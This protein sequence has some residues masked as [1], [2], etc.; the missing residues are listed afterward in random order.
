MANWVG[1]DGKK[2]QD[3]DPKGPNYVAAGWSA[4]TGG[5]KV[6]SAPG[7]LNPGDP[8]QNQT[9]EA[10]QVIADR[11]AYDDAAY[12][13][14]QIN[15][16]YNYGG[17]EGGANEA[18]NYYQGAAAG[19]QYRKGAQIDTSETGA[20]RAR[21]LEIAQLMDDRAHG[22]TPSIAEMEAAKQSQILT[23]QQSSAAAS[24]RGPA[25]LA[26]AQ[27]GAAAN[28]AA[29]ESSIARDTQINAAHERERAEAAALSGYSGIRGADAQHAAAQAA[30]D[31][32]KQRQNDAF[33]NANSDRAVGINT[34]QLGAQMHQVDTS[35]G[36]NTA[37]TVAQGN[38]DSAS[39]TADANRNQAYVLPVIGGVATGIGA[40]VTSYVTG[41]SSAKQNQEATSGGK[42]S[43]QGAEQDG[44]VDVSDNCPPGSYYDGSK[45]VGAGN[46]GNYGT[47]IGPGFARGGP[48]PGGHIALVGEE[49]P[50][51][52]VPRGDGYVIPAEQTHALLHGSAPTNRADAF[53]EGIHPLSYHYKNAANEPR[54]TP[55]GGRY[56]GISA[57]DLEAVPEV[58]RQMV[59]DGP[60]GKRIESGPTLSA[61]LAG[62]AR[63]HERVRELESVEPRAMGG[64]IAHGSKYLVGEQGPEMV[65]PQNG[66]MA[67]NP[68]P[69]PRYAG[70]TTTAPTTYAGTTT[71]APSAAPTGLA[72]TMTTSSP[73]PPAPMVTTTANQQQQRAYRPSAPL[74]PPLQPSR[75]TATPGLGSLMTDN[76]GSPMGP[77]QLR[78]GSTSPFAPQPNGTVTMSPSP[79]PP[80]PQA[81]Q[82][83]GAA[84]VPPTGFASFQPAN[85][86]MVAQ[87]GSFAN[88][89]S[90]DIHGKGD[91]VSEGRPDRRHL[92]RAE[93]IHIVRDERPEAGPFTRGMQD[94]TVTTAAGMRGVSPDIAAMR[95]AGPYTRGVEDSRVTTVPGMKG[96]STDIAAMRDGRMATNGIRNPGETLGSLLADHVPQLSENEKLQNE[97]RIAA[98]RN[99]VEQFAAPRA[100]WM[101]QNVPGARVV[102]GALRQQEAPAPRQPIQMQR[103]F[104]NDAE[105]DAYLTR[106]GGR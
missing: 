46:D 91:I 29:G 54:S 25:G 69:A 27:Q 55:T 8:N 64:P 43:Q 58:G 3:D 73:S 93:P 83:Y 32:E 22:R 15:D 101:E 19:A 16:K 26:L 34:A 44:Q 2:Y 68:S 104:S 13:K 102:G 97:A 86:S 45:C 99:R 18:T 56:L 11:K 79:T 51:L 42:G 96:E 7:S 37:A 94:S 78:G 50:E 6:D 90:S 49:G 77:T 92:D 47:G 82:V 65:V 33:F 9:P 59:S 1:V 103:E 57:Q 71:V 72:G 89:V 70:T 61:A 105:R 30:L 4:A 21:E 80:L 76:G 67:F 100:A 14:Q 40:G 35:V 84:S 63:L 74:V 106:L 66:S 38:R 48:I 98:A 62:L 87:P 52:I 20:D 36:A 39:N 53:L 95:A 81:N 75:P 24:A 31:A 60:R 5:A 41:G 28:T 23:A 17:F 12:A 10:Q 88:M 85:D